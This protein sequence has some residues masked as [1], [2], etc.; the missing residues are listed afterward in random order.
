[1]ADIDITD[2]DA[3]V[4]YVATAGQTVFPYDF[5]IFASTQ[6]RVTRNRAGVET[7]LTLGSDYAVSDV[8][9]EAGGDVTLVVGATLADVYLIERVSPIERL[10]DFQVGGAF[11]A[12]EVNR[13]LDYITMILQERARDQGRTLTLPLTADDDISTVLPLPD[14]A[15]FLRWRADL[16]GLENADMGALGAIGIPV[17][18]AQGGT[19]GTTKA[20]AQAAL[21]IAAT[22]GFVMSGK[23]VPKM[24]ADIVSAA[25]TDLNT[26][27]GNVIEI[28]ASNTISSFGAPQD[29]ALFVLYF[30]GAPTILHNAAVS[31]PIMLIS[32][33]DTVQV[34]GTT[35]IF[36]KR[37]GKWWEVTG[38]G[39]G[40]DPLFRWSAFQ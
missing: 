19:S 23:F 25:T 20:A 24:G 21:D 30:S 13:D 34:A 38:G 10:T 27:T 17:S 9:D 7:T 3:R 12:A 14:A 18:I 39:G 15:K 2:N 26:A 16:L 1:M 28:T 32:G 8:G 4:S 5:P 11:K 29:G 6:I 37:D 40:A 22:T 36:T 31:Q 33:G 35:K